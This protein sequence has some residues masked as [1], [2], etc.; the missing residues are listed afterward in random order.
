[1]PT[2]PTTPTPLTS[3]ED[4]LEFPVTDV[5]YDAVIHHVRALTPMPIRRV[6]LEYRGLSPTQFAI[7]RD[8]F[9]ARRGRAERFDFTHPDGGAVF[10]ARF[11]EDTLQWTIR[12]GGG[13][14]HD[15]TVWLE[16][17]P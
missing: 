8:F 7:I 10:R 4:S 2:Y 6:R 13:P 14:P 1:M 15:V 12:P 17:V 3:P 11:V 16:E 9:D 5:E